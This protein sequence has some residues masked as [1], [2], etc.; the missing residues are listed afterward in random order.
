M[1]AIYDFLPVGFVNEMWAI[2]VFSYKSYIK[3]CLDSLPE[4]KQLDFSLKY[5]IFSAVDKQRAA[6]SFQSALIE[7]VKAP[8][9]PNQIKLSYL[10]GGG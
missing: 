8:S 4:E 9:L 5:F 7:C 3:H 6:L 2:G 10:K 1:G